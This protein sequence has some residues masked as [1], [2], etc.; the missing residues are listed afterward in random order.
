MLMGS[1]TFT[2][3][4]I[5]N[6]SGRCEDQFIGTQGNHSLDEIRIYDRALLASEVSLLY[7][8]EKPKLPLGDSN[9]QYAVNL[10]FSD[11]LNATMTYGH[12]S[13]WN[14]SAVTDMSEAFRNRT[15]FNEDISGWGVSNVTDMNQM[16]RN[17]VAFNQPIGNWDVSNVTNL[18]S[19]FFGASAF[20][21]PVGDW[22]VS[23]V[24]NMRDIFN[25]AISFNQPIGN[26]NVSAVT[27]MRGMFYQS[28]LFNQ[29][30]GD[31]NTSSVTSLNSIFEREHQR[32]IKTS[33]DGMFLRWQ[34]WLALSGMQ[35]TLIKI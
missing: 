5:G 11:E 18:S 12:I 29:S 30:I 2:N 22:N 35:V 26:W 7:H 23:S 17:A 34:P 16:F 33:A 8:L 28:T 24:I 19:M 25:R 21:M 31:W 6:N 1:K 13:D 3:L 27:N 9:F 10:W 4:S 20:N 14:V 15:T 32:L